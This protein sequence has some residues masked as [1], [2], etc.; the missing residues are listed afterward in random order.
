[1]SASHNILFICNSYLQLITSVQMR[2]TLFPL[3]SAD[4]ILSDHSVKAKNVCE[5]LRKTDIF[6]RVSYLQTKQMTYQQNDFSD[7]L[8]VFELAFSNHGKIHSMLWKDM[9][10]EKIFYFNHDDLIPLAAFEISLENG[11]KP[12]M[13]CFEEG[14]LSYHEMLSMPDSGR[15]EL[16]M[17]LRRLFGK[18]D[19]FDGDI[20]YYC[21]YPEIFPNQGK[22]ICKI[23]H[24]TRND[25]LLQILNIVF[26]YRPENDSYLQKYIFFTSSSDIDGQP[27][28]ETELVLQIA[29]QVGKE[30]LLVK[31]HPRDGRKV[32]E[33]KGMNVSRNSSIPWEVI[34]LNH[35]FN[36]HVFLTVSSGSVLNASAMLGENIRTLFLY[37]LLPNQNLVAANTVMHVGDIPPLLEQ[38]N[39]VGLLR[40]VGIAQQMGDVLETFS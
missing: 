14:V 34:Q 21:F 27:V 19:P 7:L 23:P 29:K 10:Y 2:L 3:Q 6:E 37:P 4:F 38:L 31:M 11:R 32:Y 17:K 22:K 8:N 28:G 16:I 15:R 1:M 26:G 36:E 20:C 33:E 40:S 39:K 25:T 35:D 13:C 30:N 24:L 5:R 18:P 12:E 9:A